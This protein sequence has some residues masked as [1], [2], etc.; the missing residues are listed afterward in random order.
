MKHDGRIVRAAVMAAFAGLAG[1]TALASDQDFG[2]L[3]EQ[4][5]AAKTQALFGF[6]KPL[7]A[8]ASPTTG[9]YRTTLQSASD[10]VIL[11]HGLEAEYLTR[12][13]ANSLDM[14]SFYPLQNPTHLIA[15]IEGGRGMLSDGSGRYNPS[16]QRIHLGTGAVETVLRGMQSCDG[17]RTTPWGTVL[18][19]EE[20]DDG[21]A[22]EILNP[23]VTTNYTVA[24]RA[25]GAIVN[26]GGAPDAD[27][28][29]KRTALPILAW[30]GLDITPAGVVYAGDEERP[31]STAGNT[32]PLDRDGGAIFKFVP[33][34]PRAG[35]GSI[36]SL[37]Q[38]PLAAGSV[39]AYQAS[40]QARS[41]S[42]FPQYGQGCE[43]GEGAWVMVGAANA[44]LD[45]H[46]RGATGYYRPEDGHFDTGYDGPGVRFC[47]TNTGNEGAQNF[48]EVV[49]LDDAKPLGTGGKTDSR[50]GLQYLADGAQSRGYAVAVANRVVEGDQDFNSVDN[51]EFQPHTHV[52]YVIEDHPNGDIFACQ[53]D[54]L[55]RDIKTD[56]CVKMLSVRDSSAEP[57]GF[58]FS[59]DGSTAYVSIQHSN[60][61]NMPGVDGYATDD[62]L[63]I[64]GFKVRK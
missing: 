13:A 38:S 19:T 34:N 1:T 27:E 36:A 64:T 56:G 9:A 51:L 11:A 2:L 16:V 26:A 24:D 46:D 35:S 29:V 14:F 48:G 53:P 22:Y 31:G 30:E 25:T 47:W 3:V 57:T 33:S 44:R 10:Q 43:I 55:D 8:S 39:Y 5:L 52:M 32:G 61:G 62:L 45:A 42:S 50:T 54:G 60:D 63:K 58:I 21:G 18:A 15:C 28:I 7:T 37:A 49:C 6:N 59:P 20:T 17:I 12:G 4:L 41:S 40:C 23:L